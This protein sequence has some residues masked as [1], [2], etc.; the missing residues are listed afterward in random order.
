M[1][2]LLL[3][4]LFQYL[5]KAYHS[6]CLMRRMQRVTGYIFG[7]VWW[8]FA[9]NLIGQLE[10]VGMYQLFKEYSHVCA[11]DARKKRLQLVNA[12]VQQ[13]L[14]V[15]ALTETIHYT[16]A[17]AKMKLASGLLEWRRRI[18]LWHLQM[19][20]AISYQYKVD[21]KNIVPNFLGLMTLSIFGNDLEPTCHWIED[22]L[23]H[24]RPAMQD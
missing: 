16:P 13:T 15:I 6:V 24:R 19:G 2:V 21:R 22:G 11:R 17:G 9:L 5:P 8:E 4:F 23:N 3:I 12:G 10:G 1:T 20:T 7:T 18:P 14:F